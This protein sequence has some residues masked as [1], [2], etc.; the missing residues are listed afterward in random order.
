MHTVF[1][2]D[3]KIVSLMAQIFLAIGY[4]LSVSV[5]LFGVN[6]H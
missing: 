3:P 6:G 1:F 5:F 4:G 2:I